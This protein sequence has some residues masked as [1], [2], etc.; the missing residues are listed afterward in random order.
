MSTVVNS[1][2][3]VK[4]GRTVRVAVRP[5]EVNPAAIIIIR[6]PKYSDHYMVWPLPA[7]CGRAFKVEKFLASES[8]TYHIL[9]ADDGKHSCECKGFLRW[10]HC[11]HISSLLALCQA[12]QL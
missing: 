6:E 2:P 5:T 7:D 12:G 1:H 4:P 10:G 3:G 8:P 9:L 11:K